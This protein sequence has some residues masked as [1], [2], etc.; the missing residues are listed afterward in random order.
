ML[1]RPNVGKSTLFNALIGRR[2]AITHGS[3][4][5]TRDAGEAEWRLANRR[6]VLVDT[7]G[8][9]AGEDGLA[10]E[11]AVRSL[12][13]AR[14]ADAA[15]LVLDA[16][17]TTAEDERLMEAL[18]PL[19]DRVV[20]VVN[21]VDTADRDPLVWNRLAHGF[22]SVVGVSAA[23]RRNLDALAEA[24]EA[25]LD[26]RAPS[27]AGAA[28]GPAPAR[29]EV[30]VAILGRPNTGKSSLANRL[31]GRDRS[32]VS[33]VPGTTRDVVAG[34]F[35]W[36]GTA[37]R[38]LDTAGLR[39]R[40]HVSDAVEY[41]SAAR[42]RETVRACDLVFL[43][44]DAV[45]GLGDQDKKIAALSAAE[46]R[47]L[48]FVLN[49]WDLVGRGAGLA[50]EARERVRFQFPVLAYAPVLTVSARTGAGVSRLLETA[51]EVHGQLTRRAGTGRL[52]QALAGWVA[53]NRPPGRSANYRIRYLVQVSANPVR[54]AAFVNRLAGFPA[55]YT[56][57]LENCIRRD[58]GMPNVPVAIELRQSPGTAR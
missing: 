44:I 29:R 54:F 22:P 17:E 8:W 20:L 13:E 51:L 16:L 18:R 30:R 5:V 48:L 43:V 14:G 7:G 1:G 26:E 50:S 35:Q 34:T 31:L 19:A 24:V 56:Q 11:V 6:V 38:L 40:T 47:G 45:E 28:A 58:F 37:F 2:Q 21:K 4:G 36:R 12:R 52:N 27:E 9:Q 10:A 49:K 3:P 39:R 57:Y 46:G 42:A 53:H 55:S 15:L 33:D 41:Y 23:H 25:L 32:I